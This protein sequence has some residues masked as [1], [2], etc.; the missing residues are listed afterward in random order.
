M[1]LKIVTPPS[2]TPISVVGIDNLKE[3]LQVAT[4]VSDD[5]ALITAYLNAAWALAE[6]H[7]WRQFL[8]AEYRYTLLDFTA[9]MPDQRYGRRLANILIPRPACQSIDS[10]QYLDGDG[11]LMTLVEDTDFVVDD[12]NDICSI[13]PVVGT[14]WPSVRRNHPKAVQITYTAGYGDT[15][16]DMP[17]MLLHALRLQVGS[18]F[19]NRESVDAKAMSELPN[20]TKALLEAIEI[21]DDRLV[22][23]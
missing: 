6:A 1:G 23:L 7:T 21:R 5:D 19:L 17:D 20:A 14:S 18:W 12:E 13:W 2:V 16:A 11:T 3:H 4:D 9:Q 8:T 15:L 10:V 22:A